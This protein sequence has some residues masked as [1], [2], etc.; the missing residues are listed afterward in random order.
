MK[1]VIAT[2]KFKG[3]LSAPQVCDAIEKGVRRVIPRAHVVKVPLAD[4]GEGT[5]QSLVAAAGGRLITRRVTDPLG[6]KVVATF[7]VIDRGKTAVIEMAA[8]S[9]LVLVPPTRRNPLRTTTFGTGELIAAALGMGVEKI[10]LGIGGSATNDGGAGMAMALGARLLDG[11][12][13]S[14][15]FGGGPL[16]ELTRIDMSSF[17][18]VPPS[19]TISVA[20]DVTNPLCGPIGASAVYGPQKGAT[21][22]M[23]KQLDKNL[24]HFA[25]IAERDVLRRK[26]GSKNVRPLHER[27]GSGAAG[28]L[29]YGLC[30]FLNARLER[31]I[32]LILDHLDFETKITN[33]DL[34]FTG[35]GAIDHQ[36]LHGKVPI[37]VA[38][39]AHTHRIPVIAI[40][41]TV[42][43]EAN[44]VFH[45]GIQGL[46]S[47][48]H[49]PVE[50]KVAIRDAA[51]LLE[52]AAE[53]ALRLV[54]IPGRR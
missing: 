7:G 10:I 40:G 31:G 20:C 45:S 14:I 41:G 51:P 34:I 43:T 9:G 30:A 44:Q 29:G 39:H 38:R 47:I 42:P 48:C 23:V 53:R 1:I 33:A 28:G 52:L 32:D 6:G 2:D 26:R 35:E 5:V 25:S 15:P 12:G 27:P 19:V 24:A 8:A 11:H 46:M 13:K 37:G 3:S 22:S 18:P 17:P 36:T 4:G 50:L 54:L 49:S 21:R 16:A